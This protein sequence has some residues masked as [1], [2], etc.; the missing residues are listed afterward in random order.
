RDEVRMRT[1]ELAITVN[2]ADGG[3]VTE[4]VFFPTG[5]DAADVLTRRREVYHEKLA[6]A[7]PAIAGQASST[8][9]IH[10]RFEAKEPGLAA[11]L[12]Y[13]TLRRASLLDGL[14][15]P[16]PLALDTL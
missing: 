15:G 14:F 12:Q 9:S 4:L 6:E 16:E 7:E 10:D 11:L 2:T 1:P 13:D 3:A 8:A 5:M